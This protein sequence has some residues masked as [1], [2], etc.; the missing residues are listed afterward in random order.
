MAG[1][2]DGDGNCE[3]GGTG[4]VVPTGRARSTLALFCERIADRRTRQ[5]YRRALTRFCSWCA[6][7]RLGPCEVDAR[8][9][10]GYLGQLEQPRGRGRPTSPATIATARAA[11]RR[12]FDFLAE[13]DDL[14]G[15]AARRV[16]QGQHSQ[17]L[18]GS[19]AGVA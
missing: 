18:P 7:N 17:A 2:P 12:W 19:S 9:V 11:L 14:W 3:D 13:R 8:T 10:P 4:I 1:V 16:R 15:V 5:A 6:Q